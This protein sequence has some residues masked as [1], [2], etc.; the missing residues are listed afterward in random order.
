MKQDII[1]IG[2]GIVG[3]ATALNIAESNPSKKITILEKEDK[4]A[5]HQTGNNSGVIHAGV[6]YKPGS[7]KAINC[8]NG[9]QKLIDFCQ[10]ENI[11]YDLC[12]KLIVATREDELPQLENLWER[13]IQN[14]LVNMKKIPG[15][16]INAYEPH[17]TG[18]AAIHVPYTGIIDYGDVSKK[19]AEIFMERFGGQIKLN[20]KVKKI[21]VNNNGV[22]V[23]TNQ[24]TYTSRILINTAGLYCDKI[25]ALTESELNVRIIPFRGEYHQLTKAKSHLVKNLIYPV[26]DPKFPFLGVHFTRMIH[27]G[28]EAGPNAVWAFKREGYKK[29]SFKCTDFF[30]SLA[31]PGFRKVMRQYWKMGLGEYYRSYNKAALV[32]ALQRLVPEVKYDDIKSGGAGVRAQACDRNGKLIDDF[33]ISEN[34]FILNVLNAPS[35]AA[36]A[37]LSIGEAIAQRAINKLT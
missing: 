33:L 25:A 19:Y 1:I 32:K 37:S 28:I 5:Q 21:H 26:P 30:D 20:N 18:I 4:V 9:Y 13:G 7:L 3:L 15:E 35:P 6:Y 34:K 10:K 14:G 16:E 12:G 29:N 8:R 36:T 27:G 24:E 23:E 2:G 11:K 17:A 22:A 31:W